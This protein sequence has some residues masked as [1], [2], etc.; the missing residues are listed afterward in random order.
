M[1]HW[2]IIIV[3]ISISITQCNSN[4]NH[5]YINTDCNRDTIGNYYIYV[6]QLL[7]I[8]N[9][10]TD[11]IGSII[12]QTEFDG[13]SKGDCIFP[14]LFNGTVRLNEE[15]I[16]DTLKY[17]WN[18]DTIVCINQADCVSF[19]HNCVLYSLSDSLVASD[20]FPLKGMY[21]TYEN[22]FDK[23]EVSFINIDK[24][25]N[26]DEQYIESNLLTYDESHNM[27]SNAITISRIIVREGC[28]TDFKY[29]QSIV[30]VLQL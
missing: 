10:I 22:K 4:K 9:Q 16:P 28:I 20:I 30:E 13:Y 1:K 14:L 2:V 21:T 18:R 29:K 24:I 8:Y 19:Y 23:N 15:S 5:N 6:P 17:N 26:W 25:M 3:I 27:T 11:S 12:T 7:S